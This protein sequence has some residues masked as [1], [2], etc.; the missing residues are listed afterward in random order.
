MYYFFF[1]IL[2]NEIKL[3]QNDEID[4]AYSNLHD[5]IHNLDTLIF[6]NK[7]FRIRKFLMNLFYIAAVKLEN[8]YHFFAKLYRSD[9]INSSNDWST[10]V[11]HFTIPLKNVQRGITQVKLAASNGV[12]PSSFL[13]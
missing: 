2:E 8:F 5:Q 7:D 11:Q 13:Q 3:K 10:K 12:V 1:L 9:N 4:Y 6:Q